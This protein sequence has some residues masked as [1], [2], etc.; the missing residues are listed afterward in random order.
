MFCI[1]VVQLAKH[2]FQFAVPCAVQTRLFAGERE[3]PRVI[4]IIMMIV[5]VLIAMVPIMVSV[6][7]P[8][9]VSIVVIIMVSIMVIV[10]VII[11][12]P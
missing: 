4:I 9:M 10:V 6:M 7:V 11:V 3:P 2:C 5:M 1:A 8:I 12:V